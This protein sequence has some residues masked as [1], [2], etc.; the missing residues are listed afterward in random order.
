MLLAPILV[1]TTGCKK[2]QDRAVG[3]S[4]WSE[5]YGNFVGTAEG[6]ARACIRA[7][8]GKMLEEDVPDRCNLWAVQDSAIRDVGGDR[9]YRSATVSQWKLCAKPPAE[10]EDLVESCGYGCGRERAALHCQ[11]MSL[12]RP[13][14]EIYLQDR[15]AAEGR[16]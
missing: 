10:W 16:P 7:Y 12:A 8:Y 5:E 1:L 2:V 11:W 14:C 4:M 9:Q 3:G 6:S 13:V 15:V